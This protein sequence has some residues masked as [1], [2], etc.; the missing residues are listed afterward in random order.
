[1]HAHVFLYTYTV[2]T[3]CGL[4]MFTRGKNSSSEQQLSLFSL[5]ISYMKLIMLLVEWKLALHDHDY[6]T[7]KGSTPY[8]TNRVISRSAWLAIGGAGF[9]GAGFI[10][11][12]LCL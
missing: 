12:G 5:S 11:A 9:T 4:L 10:G 8:L 3:N 2:H 7:Q 6:S 1:M